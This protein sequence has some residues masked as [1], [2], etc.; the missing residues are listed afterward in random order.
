[1]DLL[2]LS[3][4]II[5]FLD[6]WEINQ[7]LGKNNIMI[8]KGIAQ[9]EI[10]KENNTLYFSPIFPIDK[11]Y[12]FNNFFDMFK[13]DLEI[14]ASTSP[15]SIAKTLNKK[16]ITKYLVFLNNPKV[17]FLKE[18]TKKCADI[19]GIDLKKNGN[20][21]LFMR[22]KINELSYKIEINDYKGKGVGDVSIKCIDKEKLLRIV[23]IIAE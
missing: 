11:C 17:N 9:I 10:S 19:L 13:I 3:K 1:M 2:K 14:S 12:S 6:G 18:L 20:G 23:K 21:A 16:L 5:V 7:K 4:K 8:V 22:R 15:A